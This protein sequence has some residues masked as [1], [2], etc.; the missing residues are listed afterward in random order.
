MDKRTT[1]NDLI[2]AW[3]SQGNT[4]T[5]LEALDRFGS[6]RLA[7][8]IKD[9]RNAGHE[10]KTTRIFSKRGAVIAEYSLAV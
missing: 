2:L 4:L 7:A 9:L 1:Q 3:L 6:L 10:I 8:R 5:P